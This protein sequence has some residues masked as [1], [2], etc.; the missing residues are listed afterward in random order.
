MHI[1]C[2]PLVCMRSVCSNEPST[3]SALPPIRFCSAAVPDAKATDSTL[4]PS[5][6]KYLRCSAIT[7]ATLFIWLIEPPTESAMRGFSSLS[8]CACAAA[9]H[10][11]MPTSA[12]NTIRILVL[13]LVASV[14][15]AARGHKRL[16][17]VGMGSSG[18]IPRPCPRKRA[19]SLWPWVPAFAGTSGSTVFDELPISLRV[20]ADA[21]LQRPLRRPAEHALR[22]RD[23]ERRAHLHVLRFQRR[24]RIADRDI[25]AGHDLAHD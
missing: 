12:S 24:E 15:G 6:S 21:L 3:T 17:R 1:R 23:I 10:P 18:T 25:G 20:L 16:S 11:T 5:C 4:R 19:S 9:H 7:Y 13:P 22:R 2:W 8:A 14:S